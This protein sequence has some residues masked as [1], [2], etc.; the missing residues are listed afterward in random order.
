MTA[1]NPKDW[2]HFED[3]CLFTTFILRIFLLS[4]YVSFIIGI[5]FFFLIKCGDV[6]EMDP[7]L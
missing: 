2:S 1:Q 4:W 6:C 7:K 5:F 3:K